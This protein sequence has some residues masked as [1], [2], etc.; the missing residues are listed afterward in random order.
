MS[1]RMG[2]PKPQKN[3]I[4]REMERYE[5][6]KKKQ[7]PPSPPAKEGPELRNKDG[8]MIRALVGKAADTKGIMNIGKK[9]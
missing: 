5:N 1:K 7:G 8:K 2:H 9:S 4:R 6:E 3:R